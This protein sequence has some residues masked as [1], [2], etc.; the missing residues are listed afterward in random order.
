LI[1]IQT[2]NA[3]NI[4]I[5]HKPNCI[6]LKKDKTKLDILRKFLELNI[7]KSIVIKNNKIVLKANKRYKI[8][9][10]ILYSI[11]K[12]ISISLKIL[13]KLKNSY[14]L[15]TSKGILTSTEAVNFRT[16]GVLLVKL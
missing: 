8:K 7:L 10:V 9:L 1:E 11:T 12:K 5:L 16:G 13:K 6:V 15:K 4:L 2:L 3:I 14:I